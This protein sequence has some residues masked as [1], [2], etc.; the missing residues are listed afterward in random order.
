M[1]TRNQLLCAHCMIVFLV[2]IGLGFFVLAGWVP[3]PPP[4]LDAAQTAALFTNN[5]WMRIG[6]GIIAF[7]SPLYMGLAMAIAAQLQ[8][9]EGWPPV[10]SG[11]QLLMAAVGVVAFQFPALFWLGISY[12]AGLSPEIIQVINDI[13]W[14]IFIGAVGPFVLQPVI[15]GLCILSNEAREE[16]YPRWLGYVNLWLGFLFIP[17]ALVMFFVTGPFAWNGLLSFWLALGVAPPVFIL[18]YVYTVKAIRAQ[19]ASE[20]NAFA[21]GRGIP[22]N[23]RAQEARA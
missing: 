15:I 9:I 23:V 16:V 11:L 7:A 1:N 12:R 18:N 3:P 20:Q 19:Q 8:R 13:S 4:S 2:L 21:S 10:M 5:P 17:G 6:M 14:F 22:G